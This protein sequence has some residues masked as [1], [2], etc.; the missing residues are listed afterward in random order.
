M[1]TNKH[2]HDASEFK[3]RYPHNKVTVTP[4]GHEFHVDDTPGAER[5]RWA[6]KAGTY[7]EISPDG[8][9]TS[10][11]VGN[12]QEYARGGV[13]MTVDHN[14]DVKV[15]GHQRLCVAG[16][17]HIEVA[18]DA[19]IVVGGDSSTVVAGNM[20]AAVNGNMYSGVAGD[21]N[22]NVGGNM[23]MKVA[24]GTTMESGGDHIIKAA[25]IKLN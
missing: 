25:N 3:T 21:H 2:R 20:A 13:T 11:T 9:K 18:G 5:I 17:Q 12:V 19:A 7:V 1:A 8:R 10:V 24:G 16:G 22:M 6:H 4:S 14:Q 23:N 15:H